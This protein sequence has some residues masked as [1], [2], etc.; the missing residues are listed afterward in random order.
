MRISPRAP[1]V[2]K[3]SAALLVAVGFDNSVVDFD[4]QE[5]PSLRL[6]HE[7]YVLLQVLQ[8]LHGCALQPLDANLR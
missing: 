6:V 8:E 7:R 1:R 5:A 4:E 2:A 3:S